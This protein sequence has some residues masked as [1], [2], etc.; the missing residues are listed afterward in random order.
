MN[1]VTKRSLVVLALTAS[2]VIGNTSAV[3][4]A[5]TPNP[6]RVAYD[7]QIALH[8]V[9]MEKHRADMKSFHGSMKVR[10]ESSA[11]RD[12]ALSALGTL[13]VKP[14]EPVK[15]TRPEKMAREPKAPRPST[16]VS[17]SA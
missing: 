7:A 4:A 8:K 6:N 1:T 11:L 16:S 5:S 12:S 10:N 15:P 3:F 17:P 9:A 2:F 13:P 14:T